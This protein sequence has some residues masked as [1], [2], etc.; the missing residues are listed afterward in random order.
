MG[1]SFEHPVWL[2][3]LAAFVP[4]A[5]IGLRW[6]MAMSR[7]R[8]ATAL[9]ARAL[10]TGLIAA[11]LAGAQSVHETDRLAVIGVVDCSGS[12]R[13]FA[14]LGAND[15]GD[16][17][18]FARSFFEHR[19]EGRGPDDL[20]GLV[21][22]DGR[23][24]TIATPTRSPVLDH[25]MD[26]TPIDGSDLAG[27]LRHAAALVPPDAAGRI[28]L[29]SDG[30][31]T[32]ADPVQAAAALATAG[33]GESGVS[34]PIDVVPLKYSVDDE[35]IVE[36]LDAPPRAPGGSTVPLRV[37]IRSTG[38]STGTLRL[39]REGQV[40]DLGGPGGGK[41]I[42]LTPG[43][44]VEVLDVALEDGRLSRF[45]AVYEPDVKP[46][47][48]LVGDRSLE[49]NRGE[50]FTISPGESRV[51]L[52]DGVDPGGDL[53]QRS[54]LARALRR[55]GLKV[56]VVAPEAMPHDLLGLQAHDVLILQNVSAEQMPGRTQANI[57]AF[58]RELGGGLIVVGGPDTLG[59]GGWRGSELEPL[60]P[61]KLDLPEQLVVPEAA[62][63]IVLDRSGSMGASVLGSSRSQQEVANEAA[64]RAIRSL[65]PNDMVG[66]IAF[67]NTTDVIVPLGP[68][69]DREAVARQTLSISSS[70]GTD[71]GPALREAREQ[72]LK[73]DAKHKHVVLLSDGQSQAAQTLPG[74]AAEMHA[75]GIR[76][77]SIAVGDAA[78]LDTLQAVAAAGDG[79][80]YHVLN[81]TV[82]PDVFLKAVRVAR[83]PLIR[84]QPTDVVMLD[85]GSPLAEGLGQPPQL[86]GLVLTQARKEPTITYAMATPL[87]EPLL[88]H[89]PV[90]L[91]QV[92]VFTSDADRW[93]SRWLDW[94]GYQTMWS[95]MARLLSRSTG[96]EKGE[97]RVTQDAGRV[98]LVYDA[99]DDKGRPIDLLHVPASVYGPSGEAE[100]ITLRQ[101]G[102]GRYTGEAR[103]LRGG[104]YVVIA[105]PQ[106]GGRAL[107]PLLAGTTVARGAEYARLASDTQTLKQIADASGGRVLDAT[108][109][110]SQRLFDR[111]TIR[112]RRTQSPLW[113]A[114][115]GW[116][117]AV[118]LLDVGTRRIA[119]DRLLP[120]RGAEA[121]LLRIAAGAGRSV[122]V[123]RGV[124]GKKAAA[125]VKAKTLGERDADKLRQAARARRY[126]AQ[127]AELEAL[128]QRRQAARS[129]RPEPG[130]QQKTT[131]KP[132][133]KQPEDEATGLMAAKLRAR[134]RFEEG[135]NKNG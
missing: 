102:P 101:T 67:N 20:F 99:V 45:E 54:V 51:L 17:A 15:A 111:S 62:I 86:R 78:D 84:E 110:D 7:W 83:S 24:V 108:G 28:V 103:A 119:W 89:W 132:E 133:P 65:D 125:Q 11:M 135:E 53:G 129:G 70:G 30:N 39:T 18:A 34:I 128:R 130:G 82:L 56:D 98:R 76:I 1:V 107:P 91:G 27:A 106:S 35:V 31:A 112:P 58:V 134:K 33:G 12:V 3:A 44:H 36:R 90:E 95:R 97:L 38:R 118:F 109:P 85:T 49:N 57:S 37:E 93:A 48:T 113:P 123:L 104:N 79:A 60:L 64:A 96:Q 23:S 29:I 100:Q 68:A 8:R 13:R 4:L 9:V 42:E 66:V 14:D 32:G 94:P 127:Q 55:G 63:V 25:S 6:F 124:K 10:L 114:L 75:D 120:E 87:G 69:T 26:V 72:L 46:D 126:E 2:W 74:L 105:R 81:P 77:S 116:T 5:V 19:L 40:V 122:S 16:P 71:I 22:F 41:R 21:V 92:A 50:A 80:F 121:E 43:R 117:L 59:P 61:V 115:L 47:G 73:A 131:E 52:V 88:A